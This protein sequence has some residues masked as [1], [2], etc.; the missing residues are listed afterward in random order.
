MDNWISAAREVLKRNEDDSHATASIRRRL[1]RAALLISNAPYQV[2]QTAIRVSEKQIAARARTIADNSRES[3]K[4][5]SG[6]LTGS[7]SNEEIVAAVLAYTRLLDLELRELGAAYGLS[8]PATFYVKAENVDGYVIP[9]P[10]QTRKSVRTQLPARAIVH[11]RILPRTLPVGMSVH[12]EGLKGRD[13]RLPKTR[14]NAICAGGVFPGLEVETKE[15]DHGFVV[16]DIKCSAPEKIIDACVRRSRVENCDFLA[17]PEL[18]VPPSGIA[19][20]IEELGTT[21][22][23]PMIT[24]AGSWHHQTSDGAF[25]NRSDI[26]NR[27]GVKIAEHYK[28][29]QYVDKD[30]GPESI[31]FGKD[32]LCVLTPLGICTFGICTDFCDV[33]TEIPYLDLDADYVIIVS[34]GNDKTMRGH[35][36]NA[37]RYNIKWK[38]TVFVIQQPV[39]GGVGYAL[40]SQPGTRRSLPDTLMTDSWVAY[41]PPA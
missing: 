33:G 18:T 11:H 39:A 25:V 34:M 38:G 10:A 4:I 29:S 17:F 1:F 32:I 28:F 30:L 41:P 35:I 20:L 14:R 31:K 26:I 36:D 12:L 27:W 37:H 21:A 9:L 13:G 3:E 15:H 6:V 40:F 23:N 19:A 24:V 22:E 5:T 7:S 8:E 16:S 2:K